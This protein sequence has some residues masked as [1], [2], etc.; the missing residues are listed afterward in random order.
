MLIALP[1][2]ISP[3]WPTNEQQRDESSGETEEDVQNAIGT[4]L[5]EF[6]LCVSVKLIRRPV[7]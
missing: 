7:I 4:F 3:K 2:P 6:I 5:L 1:P